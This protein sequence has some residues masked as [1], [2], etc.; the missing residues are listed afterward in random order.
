MTAYRIGHK[1]GV[2]LDTG[3]LISLYRKEA[4]LTI[5]ELAELSGVPKGTLN[6]IIAGTTK[7]PTLDNMKAIAH[8]LGKNLSDFDDSQPPVQFNLKELSI[9]KKYRALDDRGKDI[10]DTVLEKEYQHSNKENDTPAKIT[11]STEKESYQVAA[12][13]NANARIDKETAKE[14]ADAAENAP[15]LADKGF[16]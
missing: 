9:I 6:K 11:D 12:R 2:F 7:A 5:D 1:G 15:N 4:M 8:A 14:L 16:L 13:G 10:V 3:E